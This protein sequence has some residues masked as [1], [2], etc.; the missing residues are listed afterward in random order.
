MPA[1]KLPKVPQKKALRRTPVSEIS[2]EEQIVG[3]PL[4]GK[5]RSYDVKR[6]E[7]SLRLEEPLSLGD[8]LRVKGRDTDLSQRVERIAIGRRSVQSALPGETVHVS[9][10]DRVRAGDAVYKVRPS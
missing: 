1:S 9:L 3:A 5:V 4:L 8:A 7:M 2:P 6:R 10:A